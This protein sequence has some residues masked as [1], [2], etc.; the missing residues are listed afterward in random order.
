MK[1]ILVTGASGFLG[2]RIVMGLLDK[3]Y[4]IV[5]S[6]RNSDSLKSIKHKNIKV[7]EYD[8]ED[9]IYHLEKEIDEI[10]AI[11][12]L[13]AY[14]PK[15]LEDYRLAEKCFK[16]NA[17]GTLNLLEMSNLIKIKHFIYYSAGNAYELSNN[18]A[19]EDDKLYP[20]FK[21]PYYLSSK[22]VGEIYVDH[23]K[24]N[25]LINATILRV[26]APYGVAMSR[27]S[28][29]YKC[30]NNLSQSK[31][32]NIYNNDI[33]K[34]DFVFVDD[35]VKATL[36]CIE[37][38]IYGVFNV[39]SGKSFSLAQAAKIIAKIL[40]KS[41]DLVKIA[42]VNNTT[43][44]FKGFSAL[45]MKKTESIIGIIPTNLEAGLKKMIEEMDI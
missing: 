5:A 37:N 32:I 27:N 9:S 42:P 7:I 43:N 12:H 13:A 41:E 36:N 15:N 25:G 26:S 17:L 1:T 31:K 44:I 6:C 2:S 3:G 10:D 19:T 33:Y 29:V 8:F 30:I 23:Y 20:S 22:I 24:Q 34:T 45:D 38:E 11:C 4:S 18:P 21:A 35:I 40:N 14:I 28:F 16:I 39:G